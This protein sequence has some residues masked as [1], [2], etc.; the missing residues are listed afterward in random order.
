MSKI[1]LKVPHYFIISRRSGKL[2]FQLPKMSKEKVYAILDSTGLKDKPIIGKFFGDGAYDKFMTSS[3]YIH[4]SLFRQELT[5]K[6]PYI[7]PEMIILI[8]LN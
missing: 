1:E 2:N 8:K 3:I 7:K 4:K 5:L 6:R